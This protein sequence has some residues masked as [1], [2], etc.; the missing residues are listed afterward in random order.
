VA[1]LSAS[2]DVEMRGGLTYEDFCSA[3]AHYE[4]ILQR[5]RRVR[6]RSMKEP[7]ISSD[8]TWARPRIVP[9]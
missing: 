9:Q 5:Q 6:K 7:L 1:E 4:A 3:E 2:L 8:K